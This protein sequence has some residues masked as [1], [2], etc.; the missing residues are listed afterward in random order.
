VPLFWRFVPRR[1]RRQRYLIL[2]DPLPL[3]WRKLD[4]IFSIGLRQVA[5]VICIRSGDPAMFASRFRVP[6]SRCRFVH[7]P[8]P[9][10]PGIHRSVDSTAPYVYAAGS[11]H[12]DWPLLLRAFERLPDYHCI[13]AT[14]SLDGTST[15]IPPNVTLL[16]AQSPEGG[17]AL[18]QKATAVA[19]TFED[20][21]LACGPTIVLD[22]YAMGIPVACTDT[23]ACRDYVRHG[24]TGL[25]SA[26]GDADALAYNIASLLD[27][28]A[29]RG[30]MSNAIREF[31]ERELSRSAFVNSICSLVH[32]LV[33]Q[34]VPPA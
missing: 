28:P 16:P 26:P 24:V 15:R 27:D 32:D 14:Q 3:R 1:F 21:D 34:G 7:M 18:M 12:R 5:L 9:T 17:R 10:L 19:V 11:A 6:S 8:V 30:Q 2:L 4:W 13:L 33:S 31:A 25:L 23:N 22:A 29:M 20:T